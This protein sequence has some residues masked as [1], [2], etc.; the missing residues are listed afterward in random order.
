MNKK[1]GGSKSER[2]KTVTIS[3]CGNEWMRQWLISRD[4]YAALQRWRKGKIKVKL[5]C[6]GKSYM[7]RGVGRKDLDFEKTM[8]IN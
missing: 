4:K 3:K 8:Y 1:D 7:K 6:K 2:L 5:E